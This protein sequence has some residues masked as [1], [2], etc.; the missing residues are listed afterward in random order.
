R[1]STPSRPSGSG[2]S[3]ACQ[4]RMSCLR[5]CCCVRTMCVCNTSGCS[6]TSGARRQAKPDVESVRSMEGSARFHRSCFRA[7]GKQLIDELGDLG[8]A[9][10][11]LVHVR[12]ATQCVIGGLASLLTTAVH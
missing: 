7:A 11:E 9:L 1:G 3:H 10:D 12:A 4:Q 8:L 2:R 6:M 5:G